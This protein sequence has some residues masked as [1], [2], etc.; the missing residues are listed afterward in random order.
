MCEIAQLPI[1][2]LPS[3]RT[4]ICRATLARDT[5]HARDVRF[6]LIGRRPVRE[7]HG[8]CTLNYVMPIQPIQLGRYDFLG[9]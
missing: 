8:P 5:G 3:L 2:G 6:E 1:L 9:L 7:H 4:L